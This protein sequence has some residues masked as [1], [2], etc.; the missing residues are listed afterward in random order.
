MAT[1]ERSVT[2]NL[3]SL[4]WLLASL[5]FPSEGIS[6]KVVPPTFNYVEPRSKK[7][8]SM[9]FYLT[10]WRQRERPMGPKCLHSLSSY[11]FHLAQTGKIDSVAFAG[12][13]PG[14]VIDFFKE[15]IRE[16]EKYWECKNCAKMNG[17][18]FTIP[19]MASFTLDLPCPSSQ[20][21]NQMRVM[22]D[23]LFG[24][25]PTRLIRVSPNEWLLE[26]VYVIEMR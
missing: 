19:V 4:F 7:V 26:P 12:E 20:S 5:L 11:R 10:D 13:L 25:E 3:L 17:H 8:V 24:K 21:F 9:G 14:Q 22:W 2:T 1:K 16:S 15:G 18:W 23:N 6:Q